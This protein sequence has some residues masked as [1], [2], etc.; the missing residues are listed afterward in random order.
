MA[1]QKKGGSFIFGVI[2]IGIGAL[3]LFDQMGLLDFQDLI[4]TFWPLILVAIGIRIIL[5]PREKTVRSHAP[6]AGI[7]SGP[8]PE[9]PVQ[10]G[11]SKL[12]ESQVFGDIRRKINSEVFTGGRCSVVFG[13]IDI[14]A[15]NISLGTG[16]RTLYINGVFGDVRLTLPDNIPLLV[17]ANTTAGDIDLKGVRGEGLFVQRSYKSDDFESASTRLIVVASV[18]FGDIR[19]W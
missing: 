14:Q 16:Q 18:L 12:N 13:D 7:G 3:M 11:E 15:G 4:F 6:H 8:I 17:R 5:F 19:V 10:P 1:R 2:L 9:E